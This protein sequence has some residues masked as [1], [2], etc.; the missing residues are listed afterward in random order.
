MKYMLASIII[1]IALSLYQTRTIIHDTYLLAVDDLA[2]RLSGKAY[3]TEQAL[4]H[5]RQSWLT[6][7]G[8]CT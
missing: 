3:Q 5:R 1:L 2:L 8:K 6:V 4:N 7:M